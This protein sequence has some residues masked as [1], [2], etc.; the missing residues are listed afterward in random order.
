MES[1]RKELLHDQGLV[2]GRFDSRFTGPDPGTSGQYD[3]A[4]DDPATAGVNS[5]YLAAFRNQLAVDMGYR[6]RLSYRALYNSVIEPRWDM[7]HKAPGIDFPLTSP[8]TALDLA[9]VMGANPHLLLLSLN[10]L[11]DMST[12][13]FGTEYDLSHMLLPPEVRKNITMKYYASGHQ[14]YADPVAL[15]QMKSDLN[16]FYAAATSAAGR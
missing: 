10:G 12:P 1:Y 2:I 13:F 15:R 6:T 11:Y 7:H 14:T 5:A 16:Q 8:D 4:T 3:P 9:A